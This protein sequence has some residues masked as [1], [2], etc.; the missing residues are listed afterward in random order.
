MVYT[1]RVSR[2]FYETSESEETET[3]NEQIHVTCIG[4]EYNK[5]ISYWL[6]SGLAKTKS[7][8]ATRVPMNKHTFLAPFDVQLNKKII[9]KHTYQER[10]MSSHLKLLR[11]K[12]L[13]TAD[14][15]FTKI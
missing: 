11:S 5:L 3:I 1:C 14:G 6:A 15:Q 4:T 2:E 7:W 12:K 13:A 8:I 10:Q 9:S